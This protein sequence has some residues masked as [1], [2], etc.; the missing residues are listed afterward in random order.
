MRGL[1]IAAALLIAN[2]AAAFEPEANGVFSSRVIAL[3]DPVSAPETVLDKPDGARGSL[4]DYKGQVAIVT[5]WATWC[6]VCE[7]EMPI[8]NELAGEYAGKNIVFAPVSVDEAPALNLV[9]KHYE[10]HNFD[11]LPILIDRHFALAGRVGLRGTPTTLVLDKFSQV[12]AAFEGQ[13]PWSDPEMDAYLEA[14]MAAGDAE[15]SRL[16]LASVQ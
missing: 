2:P 6:H 1:M 7:I 11:N 14:L 10:S 15:S 13:A 8:I 4:T 12:V 9:A 3:T 5:L 16:L